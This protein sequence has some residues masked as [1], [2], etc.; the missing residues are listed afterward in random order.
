MNDERLAASENEAA[1]K[2]N[3]P[4]IGLVV[5]LALEALALA[6]ATIYLVVE[7]F[8][9]PA[10]SLASAAALALVAGIATVWVVFMVV[11]MLRGNAWV[12]AGTVVLQILFLAIAVGSV[13]GD[14]PQPLL[15]AAIAVPSIAALVLVFT[16]RVVAA[17]SQR[18]RDVAH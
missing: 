15:G 1:S 11:G 17:T 10:N 8:L 13:Q 3:A 12:R 5:I 16:K 9:S 7:I 2:R 18:N 6:A 14:S 4:L